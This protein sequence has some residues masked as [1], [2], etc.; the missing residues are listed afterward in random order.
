[1][2]SGIEVKPFFYTAY[3]R[4]GHPPPFTGECN[5][6]SIFGFFFYIFILFLYTILG[7]DNGCGKRGGRGGSGWG[8]AGN[9]IQTVIFFR[10]HLLVRDKYGFDNFTLLAVRVN[11]LL[12]CPVRIGVSAIF[13]MIASRDWPWNFAR[14]GK[15]SYVFPGSRWASFLTVTRFPPSGHVSDIK[16]V[17]LC[18]VRN[19]LIN[20][21]DLVLLDFRYLTFNLLIC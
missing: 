7:H 3:P 1:M 9:S 11:F 17:M 14:I 10:S 19:H 5:F 13:L 8:K 2:S 12:Q 15:G 6:F 16:L 4:R 20:F 21:G 18:W